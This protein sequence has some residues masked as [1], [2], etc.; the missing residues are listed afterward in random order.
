MKRIIQ[1]IAMWISFKFPK[2]KKKSCEKGCIVFEDELE[3][4]NKEI[5]RSNNP[6]DEIDLEM[7]KE[8]L[9]F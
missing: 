1:K 6:Y 5:D 8:K 3:L 4:H 9:G 2:R 7:I